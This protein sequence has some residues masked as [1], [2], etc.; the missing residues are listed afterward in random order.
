[1]SP[2]IQPLETDP[3]L[4]SIPFA[5]VPRAGGYKVE[6]AI[7][8]KLISHWDPIRFRKMG[9][10]YSIGSS[11]QNLAGNE[12]YKTLW[13]YTT[14]LGYISLSTVFWEPNHWGTVEFHL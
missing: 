4:K 6:L 7:P 1:M 11:Q 13:R 3:D 14:T 10:N 2:G 9:F 12:F 8:A 5:V